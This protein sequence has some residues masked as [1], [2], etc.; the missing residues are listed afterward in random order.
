MSISSRVI[1]TAA[2]SPGG[3]RIELH[4]LGRSHTDNMIVPYVPDVGVAFAVDFVSN[5]RVGFQALPGWHFPDFFDALSAVLALIG[6]G[7]IC[8]AGA[9]IA[10][11][12]LVGEV[13][14]A[15]AVVVAYVNPAVAIALGVGL[16]DEPF[17]AGTAIGFALIIGG[18]VLATRPSVKTTMTPPPAPLVDSPIP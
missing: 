10:F 5:D 11:Y 3:R 6:L 14:P 15:R 2:F 1:P 8:T 12:A 4:Y 9:F 16:L 7:V 13:G 17:T 18:S